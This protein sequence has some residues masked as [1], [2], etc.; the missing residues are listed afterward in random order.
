VPNG[1]AMC[2][3]HHRAFDSNVLG[4]TPKYQIRIRPD[5]L[6]NGTDLR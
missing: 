2:A 4:I 3:I 1:M 5:V 6:E